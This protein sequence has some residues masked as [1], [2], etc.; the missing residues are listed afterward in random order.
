MSVLFTIF[1]FVFLSVGLAHCA[2]TR[3]KR[4]KPDI[5]YI[6]RVIFNIAVYS[7]GKKIN[8]IFHPN[9]ESDVKICQVVMCSGPRGNDPVG[10]V[11]Q[12]FVMSRVYCIILIARNRADR[13][14]IQ[15]TRARKKETEITSK[16]FFFFR[17]KT[18]GGKEE[19]IN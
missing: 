19:E 6:G 15:S 16:Y 14:I 2:D 9:V 12:Y 5:Y 4:N 7:Y 3:I 10:R 13:N 18:K 11:M 17:W 1:S 8:I